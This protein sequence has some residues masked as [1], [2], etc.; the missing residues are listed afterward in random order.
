MLKHIQ[1]KKVQE[2]ISNMGTRL[3]TNFWSNS[4]HMST[5]LLLQ[6]WGLYSSWNC[7]F[8]LLRPGGHHVKG[9]WQAWEIVPKCSSDLGLAAWGG[10]QHE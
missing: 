5:V 2:P 7:W 3:Y 9:P 10:C 4:E 6:A 8:W 1:G